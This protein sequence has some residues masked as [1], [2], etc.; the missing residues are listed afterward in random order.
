GFVEYVGAVN[1]RDGTVRRLADIKRALSY[2]VTSL[3]YDP[4]SGTVF[5]TNDNK[6]FFSLRDLMAVDVRTGEERLLIKQGRI[7]ESVFNPAD[8][9]LMGVR[10]AD[11]IGT[12]VRVPAPYDGYDKV[13]TFPYGVVPYDL[14]ISPDGRLLSASVAEANGDQFLRVW[15]LDK[16]L[17]GDL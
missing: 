4:G 8:K 17:R 1:T 7:G 3:A 10:H 2:K 6:D 9:S 16:V 12:L 11:G 14:D 5:Y 13:F 15:E